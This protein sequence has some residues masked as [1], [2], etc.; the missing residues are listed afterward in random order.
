MCVVIQFRIRI[1]SEVWVGWCGRCYLISLGDAF[2][3]KTWVGA[4]NELGDG[5]VYCA[6]RVRCTSILRKRRRRLA[7][8]DRG[9]GHWSLVTGTQY[10]PLC[11]RYSYLSTLLSKLHCLSTMPQLHCYCLSSLCYSSHF[12]FL[13]RPPVILSCLVN[14]IHCFKRLIIVFF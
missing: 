14:G 13:R 1:E 6:A 3:V 4:S 9:Q 5:G 10:L 7:V 11:H 8:S 2:D 12:F